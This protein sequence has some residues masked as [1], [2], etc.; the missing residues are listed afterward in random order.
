[1]YDV[2]FMVSKN[3]NG[4]LSVSLN[5]EMDGLDIY[6]SFDNSYP[7]YFYPKYTGP[8]TVPIDATMPRVITYEAKTQPAE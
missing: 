1:M 7:D 3:D 5:A 6:Y 2:D 4:E 8:L